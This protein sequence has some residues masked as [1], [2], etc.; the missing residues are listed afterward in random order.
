MRVQNL[1]SDLSFVYTSLYPK[2]IRPSRTYA[3][4]ALLGLGGNIADTVRRLERL[5]FFLQKSS[6]V[7]VVETSPILKNPPFGYVHQDD[8]YNAVIHIQTNLT[9]MELLRYILRVEKK[10]GRKRSFANAPRTLDIDMIFYDDIIMNKK[11][12]TLPHPRWR[13]RD[14]VLLPMKEMKGIAWLKRHL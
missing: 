12:L 11:I 9:A 1:S 4:N 7:S 5:Y 2:R 10:F 14:S 6:F 8:F 13:G 3:H